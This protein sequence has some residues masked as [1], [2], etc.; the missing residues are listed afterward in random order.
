M[1]YFHIILQPAVL[2]YD[3]HIF[4]TSSSSFHGFITKQFNDLLP[5]G[6]IA[7]L[8]RAL[9]QYSSGQG[10]ESRKSLIFFF[11]PSFR[12]CKSCVYNCDDLLP[13]NI[14]PSVT[15]SCTTTVQLNGDDMKCYRF[16]TDYSDVR[17]LQSH[18][19]SLNS[20]SSDHF[21][22]FNIRK[23]KHFVITKKKSILQTSYNLA[24]SRI[25]DVTIEKDLGVHIS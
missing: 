7:Q 24:R 10:F 17:Q 18:L 1:I 14:T 16:I 21:M 15:D 23:C 25:T 2:I 4:I 8:V 19:S 12:N 3:F 11:R 9:H 22:N 6:L 13:Y 20:W 5:V